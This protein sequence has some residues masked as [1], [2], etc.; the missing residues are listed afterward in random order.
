[1]HIE[2]P[3]PPVLTTR[4]ADPGRGH[5]VVAVLAAG[6]VVA[7]IA[8]SLVAGPSASARGSGGSADN[9][10]PIASIAPQVASRGSASMGPEPSATQEPSLSPGEV[11]CPA[12]G[13]RLAYEGSIGSWQV[14][15]S[16]VIEP[17]AAS[18]PLD[19]GI[20]T[21]QLGH[22]LVSGL[23][24]CAPTAGTPGSGRPALIEH[25]WR[26]HA[27][28]SAVT[29]PISLVALAGHGASAAPDPGSDALWLL[30]PADSGPS[31]SP[32][33]YVLEMVSP[34]VDGQAGGSAGPAWLRIAVG[35]P[36]P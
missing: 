10:G 2:S 6:F 20:P 25:A 7:A 21:A 5:M 14:E 27:G 36:S 1:M 12:V 4:V 35:S 9:A 29:S 23:G 26:L 17:V 3:P 24:A 28:S 34:G 22:A 33:E 13:W 11:A 8:S 18:D 15:T 31:W 16:L 19:P 30:R 32:G